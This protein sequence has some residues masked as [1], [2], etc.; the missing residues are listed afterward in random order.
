ML[1]SVHNNAWPD[2]TDPATQLG[3]SVYYYHAESLDLAKAIHS[4]YAGDTQLPD[5]GLF[6]EDFAL[7]RPTEQPSV[8][9]ESAFITWPDEE[10]LLLSPSFVDR[11]GATLADG[12]E[13]WAE[14]RRALDP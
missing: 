13:R 2:G 1:I 11:L 5:A 10:Q 4:A 6:R 12:L 9:T 7:V 14:S 8:L 3:Y